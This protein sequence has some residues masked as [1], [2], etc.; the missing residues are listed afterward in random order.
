VLHQFGFDV[1]SIEWSDGVV[2]HDRESFP[3]LETV[4]WQG[5]QVRAYADRP[6]SVDAMFREAVDRRPDHDA[7]YVPDTGTR[8]T[9]AELEERVEAIAV[10]LEA[11]GVGPGDVVALLFPN[12]ATFVEAFFACQRLNAV[13][14]PVNTR[15]S[16]PELE[17]VLEDADP[18]VL[19]T[20]SSLLSTYEE[21]SQPLPADRVFVA[22]EA[23][24][25][26]DFEGLR[27]S[28]TINAASPDESDLACLLYTSG[29]TGD[30]KGCPG[31]HFNLVNG[32]IN[33]VASM[34]THDGLNTGIVVPLFH[35][36]GLVSC[37]LHTV[38]AAGK[39]VL[40]EDYDPVQFLE[41]VESE[42]LEY[43]IAVPTIYILAMERG[44][45]E[46]YD[47]SSWRIGAYG[48][49]PMPG[50]V[51][52]RLREA[53]PDLALVDAYGTTEAI[54]GMVTGCPDAYTDEQAD[55][56]GLPTPPTELKVVGD[57]GEP[58]GPGEIGEFA[59]RGPYVVDH[60]HNKPEKT[61]QAFEDGWLHT[62]DLALIRENGFVVL[63]GRE[64]NMIIRGGENIYPLEV[65]N[66]LVNHPKVLEAA[67]TSFPDAV[68]NERV[69]AAVTPKQ[70][71]TLTED[72]VLD[73]CRENLADYKVP[74]IVRILS[75]LPRNANGKVVPDQ[76]VPEP[77]RHGIQAGDT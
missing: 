3:G 43:V 12:E 9:Y 38:A 26:A 30:P 27:K 32:A 70:G 14:S 75:E 65:K 46:Q 21:G 4:E 10:G 54:A 24:G 53:F 20:D 71:A 41:L 5:N 61:A 6:E 23:D 55:S 16:A 15:L 45:P 74:D 17:Y 60:Y 25:F 49:A 51:V 73:H 18:A 31:R 37:L 8:L 11:A 47:L 2:R 33:Y 42:R 69:L 62:G 44:D 77:L 28:G 36:T 29:T 40:V 63:K 35:S 22:G 68:L 1:D 67:V 19:L 7:L 48:G 13:A 50:D 52:P 72:D 64:K 56:I 66:V 58:L 59:F 34:N 57:D 39:S 76:L